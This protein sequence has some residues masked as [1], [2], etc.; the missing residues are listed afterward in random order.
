MAFRSIATLLPWF[1]HLCQTIDISIG[2]GIELLILVHSEP[3]SLKLCINDLAIL[4]TF[5]CY[6]N[7]RGDGKIHENNYDQ[8]AIYIF[9]KIQLHF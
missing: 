5:D 3:E 7:E 1:F 4:W 6:H 9:K 8:D 2:I